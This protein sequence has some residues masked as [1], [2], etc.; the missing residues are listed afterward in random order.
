MLGVAKVG[1]AKVGAAKVGNVPISLATTLNSLEMP[2]GIAPAAPARPVTIVVN[3][4]KRFG[5]LFKLN[6]LKLGN[7]TAGSGGSETDAETPTATDAPTPTPTGGATTGMAVGKAPKPPKPPT[8]AEFSTLLAEFS[9]LVTEAMREGI[10]GSNSA[11]ALFNSPPGTEVIAETKEPAA[12]PNEAATAVAP[13]ISAEI[14]EFGFGFGSTIVTPPLRIPSAE[15]VKEATGGPTIAVREATGGSKMD[16][17][18][19]TTMVID[20]PEPI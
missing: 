3:P 1:A 11:E 13:A 4:D 2:V 9:T 17:G 8:T 15:A 6:G 19:G 7:V 5:R 14:S 12:V 20:C 16:L 18:G 10:G